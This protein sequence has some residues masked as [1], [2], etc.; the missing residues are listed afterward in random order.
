MIV[1]ENEGTKLHF[2]ASFLML[3]GKRTVRRQFILHKISTQYQRIT[4]ASEVRIIF[5]LVSSTSINLNTM[6]H[7][8]EITVKIG[9]TSVNKFVM[10]A[11]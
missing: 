2:N 4:Y 7:T 9:R 6:Q 8:R 3:K 10:H 5:K 1:D 11:R